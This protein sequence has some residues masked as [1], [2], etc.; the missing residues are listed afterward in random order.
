MKKL[1]EEVVDNNELLNI[2]QKIVED[3]TIK[4]LKKDCPSEI[5]DLEEALLDYMGENYLKILK[6]DFLTNGNF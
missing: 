6:Q 4:D 2:V 3:K 5:K 1:Q